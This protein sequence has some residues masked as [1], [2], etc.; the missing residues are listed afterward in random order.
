MSEGIKDRSRLKGLY[1]QRSQLQEKL[2]IL[3]LEEC[4][5]VEERANLDEKLAGIQ[6]GIDHYESTPIWIS[7][8]AL[9][10]YI[11]RV[12]PDATIETM[13]AHLLTPKLEELVQTLG[14]GIYPSDDGI[15]NLVIE[16]RKILSVTIK[17][18]KDQRKERDRVYNRQNR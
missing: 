9:K 15:C 11:E 13:K 2:R 4:K 6:K 16:D 10:R 8:H 12:N 18:T 5:I 17:E 1:I 7:E 14:N 3:N